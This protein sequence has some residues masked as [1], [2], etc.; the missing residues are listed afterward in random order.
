MATLLFLLASCGARSPQPQARS[1]SRAPVPSRTSSPS[2]TI[3]IA[4]IP[5]GT[6]EVDVTRKDA[7][8][9][10]VFDCD[11]QDVDE[12]TGHI[13]LTF[14]NGRFRW[15]ISANHPILHPLFTGIY[16]G[17][18]RVVKLVFDANTADEGVDTLLW[19]FEGKTLRFEVITVEPGGTSGNHICVARMQYQAHPWRKTH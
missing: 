19:R 1:T 6:Y 13:T 17:T 2:A 15:V 3:Q 16:T 7:I 5:E 18:G 8:R 14:K 11:P 9:F 4:P 12:N 10:G